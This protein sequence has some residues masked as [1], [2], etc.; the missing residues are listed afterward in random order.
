MMINQNRLIAENQSYMELLTTDNDAFFDFLNSMAKFYRTYTL[1]QQVSLHLHAPRSAKAVATKELW[2]KYLGTNI[3]A[4]AAPIPILRTAK[5]KI[6][7]ITVYDVQD[8][9]LY[10]K[11]LGNNSLFNNIPWSYE[12]DKHKSLIM[13]LFNAA[14]DKPAGHCAKIQ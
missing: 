13:P 7:V 6:S 5:G 11:T 4:E 1:D 12:P 14:G 10:N 2:K 9:V 8:T 3:I